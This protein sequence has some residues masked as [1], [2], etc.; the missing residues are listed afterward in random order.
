MKKLLTYN[1]S[2]KF[3]YLLLFSPCFLVKHDLD[4]DIWFILNSG[5]YVLK[6]GIPYTEPFTI[7]QG[8]SFV[9]QQWL[10]AVTFWSVYRIG[11]ESG[12]RLLVTLVYILFIFITFKLCMFL[13]EDN[14]FVSYG[15]SI[16][17]VGLIYTFITQRPYIFLFLFIPIEI[18][19]LEKFI[20]TNNSRYLLPLLI[21]SVLLINLQAA[22]WPMLFIVLLPYVVDSFKFKFLFIEGQG[23]KKKPLF[24]IILGMITAG[25]LNPYGLKAVTYLFNSY[26]YA[27]ISNTV[28]EMAPANINT[29]SGKIIF[30]TIL[31]VLAGIFL[32]KNGRYKLRYCLL[33]LGTAYMSISSVRNY[34]I[35]IICGIIPLSYYFKDFKFKIEI[36]TDKKTLTIRKVLIVLFVALYIFAICKKT[37]YISPTQNDLIKSADY[38]SEHYP[39]KTDIRLYTNY[40]DGGYLEFRGY[41]VYID[42]RAEV[43][44]KKN[45][46]KSD[47]MKE[48]ILMESGKLYYKNVLDKYSFTHLLVSNDDILSTYLPYDKDY[49]LIYSSEY[50]KIFQN[51]K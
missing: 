27:E 51:I 20:K 38:L 41:K 33:A 13:S 1:K 37:I 42:P 9:M 50:Y 40:N 7:H 46:K 24:I 17:T 23:Y 16:I 14:F 39:N 30:I 15:V 4:T 45:N 35:F 19:L 43:F 10:S 44:V 3:L 28:S 32:Y 49:K 22:M 36:K 5:R 29:I 48:F 2:Y 18:Y 21:L 26:G 11:G 31:L 12:L 8:M 47:I 34:S 6:N 25:F